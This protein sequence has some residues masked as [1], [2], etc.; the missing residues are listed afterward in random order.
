MSTNGLRNLKLV[1]LQGLKCGD[2]VALTVERVKGKSSFKVHE[3]KTKK[4]RTV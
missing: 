1:S 2:L 3:G 4:E